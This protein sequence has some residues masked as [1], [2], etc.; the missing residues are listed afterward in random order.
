ML[1][2]RRGSGE[3]GSTCNI[4]RC[5]RAGM[6]MGITR[7]AL[8]CCYWVLSR[9]SNAASRNE[10]ASLN[11]SIIDRAYAG[12]IPSIYASHTWFMIPLFS[13]SCC[14]STKRSMNPGTTSREPYSSAT[15]QRAFSGRDRTA[16]RNG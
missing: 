12:P 4:S 8:K 11:M 16:I 2:A 9:L 15:R 13:S 7:V 3:G 10:R 5:S 1:C 6:R 14:E